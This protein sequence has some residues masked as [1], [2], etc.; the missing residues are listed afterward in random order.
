MRIYF[1]GTGGGAPSFRGL[2]S[3]LVKRE[4]ISILLDCGEGTQWR[5]M[6]HSL[7]FSS[8]DAVF[9]THMHGDHVLGLPGLIE[10]MGLLGRK[11]KLYLGGPRGMK[12]FLEYS[13]SL[14]HF[15]PQFDLEFVSSLELGG[16]LVTAFPTCHVIESYGYILTERD[17]VNLDAERLRA[18]GISDWRILKSLKE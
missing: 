8:I 12:E 2:P 10:T 4:G 18:E 14:T 15:S 11:K 13:F 17:R 9:I 16:L 6:Q 7:G 1:I 3:I 5:L